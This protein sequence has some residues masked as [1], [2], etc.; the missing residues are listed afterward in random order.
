M[1]PRAARA[2]EWASAATLLCWLTAR[3][4]PL[5]SSATMFD[6]LLGRGRSRAVSACKDR[7]IPAQPST[8]YVGTRY[9]ISIYLAELRLREHAALAWRQRG[10][11]REPRVSTALG[12]VAVD[13]ARAQRQPLLAA[14]FKSL[15]LWRGGTTYDKSKRART[16]ISF[17][18]VVWL[19][20]HAVLVSALCRL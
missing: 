12:N 6:W 3:V 10:G 2:S 8:L 4:R 19:A 16:H 17:S 18:K 9:A 7:H 1:P 13:P 11:E 14:V 5:A 20:W 15:K